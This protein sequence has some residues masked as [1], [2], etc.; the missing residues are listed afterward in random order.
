M[1]DK[2]KT[3]LPIKVTVDHPDFG[4]VVFTEPTLRQLDILEKYKKL[5]NKTKK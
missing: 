5:T 1:A 3:S 2:Q 4:Q